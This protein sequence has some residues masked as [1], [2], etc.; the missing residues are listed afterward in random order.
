M[1]SCLVLSAAAT[2]I[3]LTAT[4][5]GPDGIVTVSESATNVTVTAMSGGSGPFHSITKD[6]ESGT[7]SALIIGAVGIIVVGAAAI[8]RNLDGW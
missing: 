1:F 3:S 8:L 5:I 4:T 2:E 7:G 6:L